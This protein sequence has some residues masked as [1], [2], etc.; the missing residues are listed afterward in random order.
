MVYDG[1]HARGGTRSTSLGSSAIVMPCLF[2]SGYERERKDRF[3]VM[4]ILK[5]SLYFRPGR[6]L[7]G[8]INGRYGLRWCSSVGV[9][10]D[11]GLFRVASCGLASLVFCFDLSVV[12]PAGMPSEALEV[13]A[14]CVPFLHTQLYLVCSF[15]IV[16]YWGESALIPSSSEFVP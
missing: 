16:T 9:V 10:L 6:Y 3:I 2:P 14:F 1:S 7:R 8:S 11:L 15:T 5:R 4:L 13:D 12:E